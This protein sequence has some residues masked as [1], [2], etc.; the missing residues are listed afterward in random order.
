M[1]AVYPAYSRTLAMTFAH[2]SVR[3]KMHDICLARHRR[4][5]KISRLLCDI[6]LFLLNFET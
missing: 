3:W 5:R 4:A 2:S 6:C 1:R